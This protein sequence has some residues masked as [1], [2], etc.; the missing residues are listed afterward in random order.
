MKPSWRVHLFVA[1]LVFATGL[2]YGALTTRIAA[3]GIDVAAVDRSVEPSD[4]FYEFANGKWLKATTIPPDAAQVDSFTLVIDRTRHVLC[5]ILEEAASNGS[6]PESVAGKVGAYYRSGMDDRRIEAAG[7]GPLKPL[8]DRIA[9]LQGRADLLPALAALHR[10]QVFAGFHL[11]AVPD[12]EDSA[13]M[14]A[15]LSQSGLGLP[16]RDYYLKDDEKTRT[17]RSAYLAHVGKML[18]M[19]GATRADPNQN[20]Q[21]V[22]EV[23]TR[24]ARA[25]RARVDLRDPKRNY[26]LVSLSELEQVSG[27]SWKAYFHGLGLT[28]PMRLN[29]GQ[30]EFVREL[31]RMV[32]DLPLDTWKTYLRWQVVHSLAAGLSAQFE[33]ENF[34]FFGTVLHGVP[35][36]HPRPQR[37]QAA[38]DELLGDALGQLYVACAFTPIVQRRANDLVASVRAALRERLEHL[39]W[40]SAPTRREALRKL[41]A[42]RVKVGHTAKA[43]DYTGLAFDSPVYAENVLAA[44]AFQSRQEW[45]RIDKPVDRDEWEV[46][47]QTVNAYYKES[48]NEIVLPAA[49]WQRPFFD[50]RADEAVNYGAIGMIIGHEM[51][52]GFDDRGRRFDA[53]GNLRDWWASADAREFQRRAARLV[54]QYNGY[55]ALDGLHL[56]GQL[57]IGE[58]I[59]DLGG[60]RIAWLAMKKRLADK[61][62]DRTQPSQKWPIVG[63]D[64]RHVF[65]AGISSLDVSTALA[66][67][68]VARSSGLPRR[69]RPTNVWRS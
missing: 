10:Y 67:A 37:I 23:E 30:P 25:S 44:W 63:G 46:T 13:R 41:D 56:N 2:E 27:S 65:G 62:V 55:V 60:L 38:T 66:R 8:L 1:S 64:P 17:L 47:P 49:I 19:L 45:S 15:E 34:H 51:T 5:Q 9:A 43:R 39:D 58:N 20:A 42:M 48:R 29:V 6:R 28:P 16:D 57:T 3:Q 31:G 59:A 61:S 14:L 33:K 53:V 24:L 69:S 32:I 35:Q 22:L 68:F 52:H 36:M 4:D 50:V 21:T 7:A 26:H 12:R 54:E 18:R 11:A 40:M